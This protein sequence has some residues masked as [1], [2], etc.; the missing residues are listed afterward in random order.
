MKV[1]G[2]ALI[3]AAGAAIGG[4]VVYVMTRRKY[5]ANAEEQIHEVE[6][7]YAKKE[8]EMNDIIDEK[9]QKGIADALTTTY[10]APT[11]EESEK[12]VHPSMVTFEI[13]GPDQFGEEYDCE[14]LTLYGDGI[15][16]R[17]STGEWIKDPSI[18]IGPDALRHM[19]EYEPD[20]VEVRNHDFHIDYEVSKVRQNYKDL[21]P[22]YRSREEE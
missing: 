3:F 17:D 10:R 15:I 1:I 18:Y 14:Y 12:P 13:I 5:E 8:Q 9:V 20:V 6:E 11:A 2:K 22:D 19:G 16:A 4:T 21:F 7:H